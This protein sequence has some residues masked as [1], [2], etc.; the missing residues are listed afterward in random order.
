MPLPLL[1]RPSAAY[2]E[3]HSLISRHLF[4]HY[5]KLPEFS[6]WTSPYF[7]FAS[8]WPLIADVPG[9]FHNPLSLSLENKTSTQES[10][11]SN[12]ISSIFKLFLWCPILKLS[13]SLLKSRKRL[14]SD[15]TCLPAWLR[16]L[17]SSSHF[18]LLVAKHYVLPSNS[19][20]YLEEA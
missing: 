19:L 18:K 7:S 9:S 8:F 17:L 16:R 6:L 14:W 15:G 20:D 12:F 5:Q 3:I 4:V 11:T 1:P 2:A 10:N 13:L